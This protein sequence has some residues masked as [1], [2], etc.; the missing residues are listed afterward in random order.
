MLQFKKQGKGLKTITVGSP[1][2][3]QGNSKSKDNRERTYRILLDSG[4]DGDIAFITEEELRRLRV[5]QK[6]YPDIWGTSNGTFK[7][8]RSSTYEYDTS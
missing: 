2:Y 6:A 4:S 7:N 8:D 5:T 3:K 1:I